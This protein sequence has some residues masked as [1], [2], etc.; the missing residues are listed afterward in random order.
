VSKKERLWT[1]TALNAIVLEE[2]KLLGELFSQ[3]PGIPVAVL[4]GGALAFTLYPDPALRPLT[5]IDLLVLEE[6]FEE[7]VTRLR[8]A[9]YWEFAPDLAPGL[10]RVLGSHLCLRKCGLPLS[11]EIHWSL[12]AS[13]HSHYAPD[14]AWFWDHVEPLRLPFPTPLLTLDPTAHL[15]YLASHAMLQHGEARLD[16]KWLY[17]IHL[18]ME[19]EAARINWGEM[20]EQAMAFHWNEALLRALRRCSELFGTVPPR[21]V[22][23]RLEAQRDKVA[24]GLLESKAV[25][26]RK[27]KAAWDLF[28]SLD[29]C[30]K[31]GLL[32]GFLLPSPTFIRWRYKPNPA[33]AWPFFYLYR[34]FD[35]L[36][37]GFHLA[38]RAI[39]SRST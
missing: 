2:L 37:E 32:R 34:W 7:A 9:G 23:R 28:W 18:L 27:G 11:L 10:N 29:Q 5:D 17:D 35:I 1:T 12:A 39:C 16:P 21:E 22:I 6:R 36:R 14:M 13:T 8:E 19:K 26:R 33:W 30:G 25:P 4:K 31:I 24:A 15:L 38:I 3:S 20:V